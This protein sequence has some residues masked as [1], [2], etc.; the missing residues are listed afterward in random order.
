M[1]NQIIMKIVSNYK[2]FLNKTSRS[3]IVSKKSND[4]KTGTEE[5]RSAVQCACALR[6]IDF[7]SGAA[8]L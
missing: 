2:F 8:L 4:R 1:I 6:E 3:N 7:L 5:V